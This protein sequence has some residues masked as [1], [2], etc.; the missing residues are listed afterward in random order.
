M[1]LLDLL[2]ISFGVFEGLGVHTLVQ[3]S[4][5]HY[6]AAAKYVFHFV[7]PHDQLHWIELQLEGV[8]LLDLIDEPT[9][10]GKR[11]EL[12]RLV[13]AYSFVLSLVLILELDGTPRVAMA[14]S[15]LWALSHILRFRRDVERGLGQI[16]ILIESDTTESVQLIRRR[17]ESVSGWAAFLFFLESVVIFQVKRLE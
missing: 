12:V 10:V 8:P 6:V 11:P 15:C 7:E 9:L 3:L 14:Q 2:A 16:F 4:L 5:V 13:G 17:S 1:L